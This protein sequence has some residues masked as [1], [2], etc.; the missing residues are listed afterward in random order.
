MDAMAK[1]HGEDNGSQPAAV[2]GCKS[3][4][5]ASWALQDAHHDQLATRLSPSSRCHAIGAQSPWNSRFF[6]HPS[7]ECQESLVVDA[8]T[9]MRYACAA[10]GGFSRCRMTVS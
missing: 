8:E 9:I 10:P 6:T 5:L 1:R 7:H 2:A 4:S 3:E